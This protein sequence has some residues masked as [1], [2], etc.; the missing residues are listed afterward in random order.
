MLPESIVM[1]AEAHILKG[2]DAMEAIKLAFE[3]EEKMIVSML[4]GSYLNKKGQQVA[5]VLSRAVYN[6]INKL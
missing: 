6:R 4:S 2:V 1:R 3:E 5:E